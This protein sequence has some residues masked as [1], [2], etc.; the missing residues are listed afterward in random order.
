MPEIEEI[1]DV[2]PGLED[3]E[4]VPELEEDVPELEADAPGQENNEPESGKRQSKGELKARK[5]LSKSGLINVPNIARVVI[6]RTQNKGAFVI[7]NPDVFKSAS[8]ETFVIYGAIKVEDNG[9]SQQR[10]YK[11]AVDVPEIRQEKVASVVDDE[12]VDDSGVDAKDIEL[13]M[14]QANVS[15][16]KAVNALKASGNDIVNAIMDLTL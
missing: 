3:A 16:A 5:A 11:A 6:K 8:N 1:Q 15:R 10:E 12:V 14:Q 13:V 7:D 2:I 4:D 9:A